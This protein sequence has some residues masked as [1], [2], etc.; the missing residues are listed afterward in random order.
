[1]TTGF[2][3]LLEATPRHSNINLTMGVNTD[4]VRGEVAR[5]LGD[6]PETNPVDG[7]DQGKTA[8]ASGTD[9]AAPDV[10]AAPA[11]PSIGQKRFPEGAGMFRN[12]PFG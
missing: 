4:L 6:L 5:A 8:Q 7:S 3:P 12:R 1:M 2:P 11:V 10:D 9:G